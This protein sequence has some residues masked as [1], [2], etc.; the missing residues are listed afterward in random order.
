MEKINRNNYESYF[1]DYLEGNLNSD[2]KKELIDFLRENPDLRQELDEFKDITLGDEQVNFPGKAELKRSLTLFDP[3]Y[4]L[5]DELSIGRL[6]GALSEN[7]IREFDQLIRENPNK[8]KEYELYEKTVLNPDK[9]LRYG[10]KDGLK[11]GKTI[12]IYRKIIYRSV[13]IA[14]SLLLLAS[15]YF[16]LPKETPVPYPDKLSKQE[17]NVDSKRSNYSEGLPGGTDQ[18]KEEEFI[19]ESKIEYNK[20]SNQIEVEKKA[21]KPLP[22]NRQNKLPAPE[23]IHTRYKIQITHEPVHANLIEPEEINRNFQIK[24]QHFNSY[25]KANRFLAKTLDTPIRKNLAESDFSLWKIADLSFEGIS[26]LTGKQIFLERHY[27]EQ[28]NL[29]K[30]AF[31]T[32]SFSFSADMKK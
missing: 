2:Q 19:N 32:E 29:Q 11:K 20:V 17:L 22:D 12:Q 10:D 8:E 31:Q 26:K 6:E 14:A 3:G 23:P 5:F 21:T 1:L 7:Q 4:T 13:A 30:L 27:N 15:L 24:G 25:D 28:G 18:K 16:F 9:K